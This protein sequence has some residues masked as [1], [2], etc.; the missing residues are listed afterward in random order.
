MTLALMTVTSIAA[1]VLALT[2]L[3][4]NPVRWLLAA[5]IAGAVWGGMRLRRGL[6]R[7]RG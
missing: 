2:V 6:R 3:R 5:V 1:F 7:P 4:L